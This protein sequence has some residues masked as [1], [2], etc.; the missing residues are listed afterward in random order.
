ANA[1]RTGLAAVLA[2]G[3][4]RGALRVGAGNYGG[5]LGPHHYHL[6]DLLP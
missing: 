2:L 4:E 1:M 3:P 5:K 6:K